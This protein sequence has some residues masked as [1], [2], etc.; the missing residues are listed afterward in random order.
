MTFEKAHTILTEHTRNYI[1][2]CDSEA[3]EVAIKAVEKQIPQR[4]IREDLDDF[5]YVY[6]C[7]SCKVRFL[8]KKRYCGKCGQTLE[9]EGWL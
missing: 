4:V 8:Q 9:W 3:L 7:P 5:V 1:P 2:L 6:R